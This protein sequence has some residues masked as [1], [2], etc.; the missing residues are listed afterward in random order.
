M[1][2]LRDVGRRRRRIR[3]VLN[4]ATATTAFMTASAVLVGMIHSSPV[5]AATEPEQDDLT[6]YRNS[7]GSERRLDRCKGAQALHIGGPLLKAKA[8]EGLAGTEAELDTVLGDD[9]DWWLDSPLDVAADADEDAGGVYANAVRDR[10][11]A[12]SLANQVYAQKDAGDHRLDWLAPTFGDAV[13]NFTIGTQRELA[14]H[15]DD[16]TL[17]KASPEALARAKVIAEENR[18]KDEWHD[19]ASKSMLSDS[20]VSWSSRTSTDIAAYLKRGG[21]PTV[22]P[23]KDSPEYRVEV[24]DLKQ[25]W[26]AC[27]YANPYDP[28]RKLNEPVMAAMIE[29]ELEYAGQAAQRATII[30]AEAEAS[31]ATREATDDLVEALGQAWLAE[32]LLR[33]RKNWQDALAGWPFPT[34]PGQPDQAMY[35]RADADLARYRANVAALVTSAKAQAAKATAAAQRATTAQQQ[36]WAVADTTHV[37]RG[38]GLMYAQQSVQVARASAAAA[39]AAAKATETALAAA[40]ATVATSDALLAKAKTESA[41]LNTEFRRVAA[42][43]AAA[44][45]K[46]AA[47]SAVANATAA[48][49]GANTAKAARTAAEEKRDKAKTAAATAASERAKAE[50]EKA[51][52]VASRTKAATERAKAKA[53]EEKA[54]TQ[55]TTAT[56]AGTAAGT[57]TADATAKRKLADEKAKAAQ[58]AREKAVA[59]LRTKQATAARAA[60]LEAAATAAAGSAAAA[61]TRAAATAARTAA[62]EAVQAAAAAQT[63][64]DQATTAAVSARSAATTAEGAAERAKTSAATAWSAYY[65]SLGEAS[66]AHAAAATA[67][68]ASQDAAIRADHAATASE[69]ATEL[70]KKAQRESDA[71]GTSAAEAV[72]SAATVVGR[73]YAAAQAALAARDASKAAITSAAEAVALG[74]PYQ[75]KDSAAAFAVL[76]G[77]SSKTAAEQQAAAAAAKATAAAAAAAS[78]QQTA[79]QATGDAKLAAEAAARAASDSVRAVEAATRAQAS[80]TQAS[81]AQKGAEAASDAAAG[82]AAQSG[83]DALSARS[84]AGA[85]SGIAAEAAREATDAEKHAAEANEKAGRSSE[86]ALEAARKAADSEKAAKDAEDKASDA[87]GDSSAAEEAAKKAEREQREKNEAAHEEALA[88]GVTPIKG[89]ASNWPALGEREQQILLGA[90]GQT[91]VDDYRKGLAAVSVNVVEW[92]AANG[93][94]ILFEQLDAAKVKE[95]LASSDVDDCLWA[96]VDIPSSSVIVGR[97]PALALA[98][99]K[100]SDGMRKIFRDAD[101]ALRRLNEL[102]TVISGARS[103]PRLERCLAGVAL[104]AGGARTKAV[105]IQG[106]SGTNAQLHEVIGDLSWLQLMALGQATSQDKAAAYQYADAIA[107]RKAVLEDANRPYAMSSF[108]DGITLHAPQFGAE[109][110]AFTHA[111][112]PKLSTRLGWDGHTNPSAESLAKARE[113][114]EQNRGKDDWHDFAADSMLRSANTTNTQFWGG[115]TSADIATYL[116]HGGFPA[117]KI[118]EGTAAFRVEVE[119][120]K[121][122]WATCNH[123]DPVDPRNALSEVVS[124]ASAEWES[125]YAGQ[126]TQRT[127]IMRAEADAAAATKAATDNMIEAIGQAWLADQILRWQKYWHDKLAADPDHILKPKQ[128]LFDQAKS[129]LEKARGKVRTLVTTAQEQAGLATAAAQRAVTAQQ[130]AWALADAAEAPRGRGLMYAQQSVQVARASGAAATA[131]AKATETA[132][133]AANATVSTSHT[134]LALAQTQT[135]AVNTEFRRIAAQ[136]A[137]AQAKAA[138]DSADRHAA[139]AEANLKIAQEA[140]ATAEREEQEAKQA[141]ATAQAKRAEAELERANAAAH[142]A[143]AE[144]ERDKASAAEARAVEEQGRA[145]TARATADGAG[146][147]AGTKRDDAAEAEEEARL[148]RNRALVAEREKRAA[149]S[150]AAALESAAAAAVGTEAATETRQL[151]TEARTAANEATTAATN[152]RAA[153]DEAGTA[154]VNSRSAALRSKGAAKRSEA[155]ADGAWAAYSTALGSAAAAHAA[156]AT[157]IDASEAAAQ[158]ARNAEAESRKASAA[159]LLAKQEAGLAHSEALKTA[160]WAAETAG[161]AY[162][163]A[164]AASAARDTVTQTAKPANEAIAI[165]TPYQETDASAGFAVLTGQ[166]ALTLSEQQAKAAEAKATQ[167]AAYAAEAQRLAD[168]AA[169]D[170]KLAA[171]AAAAAAKDAERAAKA[172]KRAQTAAVEAEKAAKAAQAAAG[173]ADGYAM[174]AGKDALAATSAANAAMGEAASADSAATEAEKDAAG[175]RAA[176]TTAENDAAAARSTATQAESDATAAETSASNAQNHAKEADE[177]AKRAEEEYRKSVVAQQAKHVEAGALYDGPQLGVDDEELL[178]QLCGQTCVDDYK[179]ARDLASGDII[180]WVKANGGAILLELFGLTNIKECLSSGDFEACMWAIVDVAANLV[181]VLKIPAVA[182]ALYRIGK[183]LYG[184]FEKSRLA[185]KL[186]SKYD[187]MLKQAKKLPSCMVPQPK[188][189]GAVSNASFAGTASFTRVSFTTASFSASSSSSS[190]RGGWDDLYPESAQAPST[191]EVWEAYE[192]AKRPEVEDIGGWAKVDPKEKCRRVVANPWFFDDIKD[193]HF[194]GG[195]KTEPDKGIWKANTSD[196]VL[197]K[198]FDLAEHMCDN[199]EPASKPRYRKCTFDPGLG[200]LG[201]KHRDGPELRTTQVQVVVSIDGDAI[202][203]Y[204]V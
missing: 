120:L 203:M 45:A 139:E 19:W 105:A 24:E 126:N 30:R 101:D 185:Q 116:R 182:K 200:I 146:E 129:D 94:Q 187:A 86:A 184:F 175:A 47:D 110:M 7:I 74:S 49:E 46:A 177:A 43:E 6:Q 173:R 61:E 204:P 56:S 132:L 172:V 53:A 127:L 164:Q 54:A 4:R 25:A 48:A 11:E 152:A 199:W 81:D 135:H 12:L 78:A 149:D 68:D 144:R 119:N 13:W 181:P 160:Q 37:P 178:R 40:K 111:S 80:A 202:T 75:E 18:G 143:T 122:A 156:A 113:I 112:Q 103:T 17:S 82:H 71:A 162:A 8:I 128:A 62:N 196:D 60:A 179:A 197:K 33:W 183:A 176:A 165:G 23:V 16:D 169:A 79:A 65:A 44:Q 198:I 70:A 76:V 51:T 22:A 52:A 15:L 57:A 77:Q 141:S 159:A 3:A 166:S 38:R 106:L 63:A 96:L 83:N 5:A 125:E 59:A 99:E 97:V 50:A 115:I 27:D 73:A 133:N 20:Q 171:Q 67:L 95:C 42:E 158:N 1:S 32:Q 36:A 10:D 118:T 137:A 190:S 192:A 66:S 194:D 138:A 58:T 140:K 87:A 157:A 147:A 31:A 100:V 55:Q 114:T 93:G 154:A 124:R 148:A 69:N 136:E 186:L 191:E 163:V 29:W 167:A 64:A 14:K 201:R 104:H 170:D 98:I 107:A 155:A 2:L 21:F 131:A 92:A 142:R 151:A 108:D 145:S 188:P 88:E 168:R 35:D 34:Y 193:A 180:E 117:K 134:L 109:V 174:Q 123:G 102:T 26:A 41:A 150:R 161:H 189:K 91:C 195:K 72:K 28:S 121:Q 90:C 153:A 84:T 39:T 85:V 130:D 9:L 89:G